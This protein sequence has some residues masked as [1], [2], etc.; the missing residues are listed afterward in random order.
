[1]PNYLRAIN[2]CKQILSRLEA[3]LTANKKITKPL[4][5]HCLHFRARSGVERACQ[6][7]RLSKATETSK[8]LTMFPNIQR[9][10]SDPIKLL[11]R[12]SG[13]DLLIWISL[14]FASFLNTS[15]QA[16]AVFVRIPLRHFKI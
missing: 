9:S 10:N 2:D 4:F 8:A 14:F 15:K 13:Q 3:R 16:K 6:N 7:H 12:K 11:I 1:M 5:L